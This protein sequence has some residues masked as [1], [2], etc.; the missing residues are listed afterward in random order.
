MRYLSILARYGGK[1]GHRFDVGF[2]PKSTIV[3]P[4]NQHNRMEFWDLAGNAG[5]N[6]IITLP[7]FFTLFL[8]LFFFFLVVFLFFFLFI[9]VS[10][11][12]FLTEKFLFGFFFHTG[13][14]HLLFWCLF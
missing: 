6:V 1:M 7:W 13:F 5:E 10:L 2:V 11:A 4:H 3:R 8:F 9:C 12:S 14:L